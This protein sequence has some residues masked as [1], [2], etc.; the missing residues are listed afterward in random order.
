[1]G[2]PQPPRD[3]I[4]DGF[5]PQRPTNV[6]NRSETVGMVE[7]DGRIRQVEPD[8]SRRSHVPRPPSPEFPVSRTIS[9]SYGAGPS[10]VIPDRDFI[11]S[12]SQ[13]RLDGHVSRSRDGFTIISEGAPQSFV[14][15][16]NVQDHEDHS[17]RS[18]ATV[19]SVRPRSPV[20]YVE[21]PM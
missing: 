21:R 8:H 20:R 5:Y 9:R 15:Q 18:F 11:H 2:S 6:Q 12:F 13:S 10:S 16:R 17:A 3:N 4:S 7:H 19:P 14:S 1:M